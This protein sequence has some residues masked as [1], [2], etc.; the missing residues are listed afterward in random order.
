MEILPRKF[1]EVS[2][3]ASQTPSV[4]S[5][6]PP[7]AIFGSKRI[8]QLVSTRPVHDG[9]LKQGRHAARALLR[10]LEKAHTSPT[11]L[12]LLSL[13]VRVL[14][15]TE[16][17]LLLM[18]L[19]VA[20]N[21]VFEFDHDF[22]EEVAKAAAPLK[23]VSE[24]FFRMEK[25]KEKAIQRFRDELRKR[26]AAEPSNRFLYAGASMPT[27]FQ[28]LRGLSDSP[29]EGHPKEHTDSLFVVH[30]SPEAALRHAEELLRKGCCVFNSQVIPVMQVYE[31]RLPHPMLSEQDNNRLGYLIVDWEVKESEVAGRLTREELEELC[32][33]FPLWLYQQME[34]RG[35]VERRAVVTATFKRKTRDL[36][37]GDRK[38]SSHVIYNV[39]GVP[40]T[41]L[42]HVLRD[43]LQDSLHDI[44]KLKSKD[45]AVRASAFVDPQTGEDKIGEHPEIGVDEASFTGRTGVAALFSRK[46]AKD[47]YPGL[48]YTRA[49]SE[50]A[51]HVFPQRDGLPIARNPEP[52]ADLSPDGQHDLARLTQ[53]Q[54]IYYMYM[55]SCSIPKR[56]ALSLTRKSCEGSQV[57][58]IRTAAKQPATL[59]GGGGPP[60][61]GGP[62]GGSSI[63]QALPKW[64]RDFVSGKR[65]RESPAAALGYS[66]N[67]RRLGVE[68]A[69]PSL[70]QLTHYHPGIPCPQMLSD[71]K[72]PMAHYHSSNGIIVAVNSRLPQCVFLCCTNC[73]GGVETN[74]DVERVRGGDGR[75]SRWFRLCEEGFGRVMAKAE[76]KT[77]AREKADQMAKR[78]NCEHAERQRKLQEFKKKPKVSPGS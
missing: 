25:S 78:R 66:E 19:C 16:L 32:E 6:S 57:R 8:G 27:C 59:V 21:V 39:C 26:R 34:K 63:L 60:A 51:E 37:G 31:F 4:H 71:P 73:R 62:G 61:A 1:R 33:E 50:G 7:F 68:G 12:Y 67:I 75:P 69:D 10:C 43:C 22:F 23:P 38:H 35:H 9:M 55:A 29:E 48:S 54:A 77:A 56:G 44:K 41:T 14:K 17:G 13:P 2:H 30:S 46:R 76:S 3:N 40:T 42:Q 45:P 49:F 58:Q 20:K 53:E 28:T 15:K 52:F 65:G 24:S 18:E 74:E 5:L 11:V 47:P 70:W 64:F 36:A 72:A